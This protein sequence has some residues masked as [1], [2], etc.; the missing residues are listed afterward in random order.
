LLLALNFGILTQFSRNIRSTVPELATM[1]TRL[2][3]PSIESCGACGGSIEFREFITICPYC[4][5]ENYRAQQ[6]AQVAQER[7]QQ[8]E[9]SQGVLFEALSKS[10]DFYV[11]SLVVI[12][13]LLLGF[14]GLAVIGQF[15][16][17]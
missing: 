13:L 5:V 9:T 11:G 17:R 14:A 6:T 3:T 1:Q 10:S 12:V 8:L 15:S 2:P 7:Q 16:G 4:N